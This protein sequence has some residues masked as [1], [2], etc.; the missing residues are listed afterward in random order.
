M[1]GYCPDLERKS[2]VVCVDYM[3][4]HSM[5]VNNWKGFLI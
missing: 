4:K 3:T 2:K 5:E 1:T